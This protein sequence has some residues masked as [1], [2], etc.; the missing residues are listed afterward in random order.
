M[1]GSKTQKGLVWGQAV[2]VQIKHNPEDTC[3]IQVIAK[4]AASWV[5][6]RAYAPKAGVLGRKEILGMK[7]GKESRVWTA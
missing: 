1:M 7:V 2:R 6:M 4:L 5:Q 3:N